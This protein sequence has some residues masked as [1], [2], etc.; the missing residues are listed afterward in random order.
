MML[1]A[2]LL[3][4]II[5]SICVIFVLAAEAI[6]AAQGGFFQPVD[7][8]LRQKEPLPETEQ[9][10]KSLKQQISKLEEALTAQD[11][12]TAVKRWAEGVK[13]R[14]GALQYAMLTSGLKARMHEELSAGGWTTGT[15][16]PWVKDYRIIAKKIGTKTAH[17]E[18]EFTCTDS[19]GSQF[20]S[21]DVLALTKQDG[22][23]YISG[24]NDEKDEFAEGISFAKGI[25][26]PDFAKL[27]AEIKDWVEYSRRIASA[28]EKHYNGFRFVLVTAGEKPTGGYDVEITEAVEKEGRLEARVKMTAPG[29]DD[30]VIAA[31]TY[32]FDLVIVEEKELPLHFV[33]V[34]DPGR[35]FM[36]LAGLDALE[37]PI[38]A[39][40]EWIKVFTPAPGDSVSGKVSL[41]G[42]ASVFEGTV[43]YELLT[44]EGS[45]VAQGF[46]TAAMGDWGFFKEEIAL[47]AGLDGQR[48][49]LRLYS[50][51]GKDGSPLFTVEIPLAVAK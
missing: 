1:K 12:T 30:I 33:D 40:S 26:R 16:S 45:V 13:A 43:S 8:D 29:R 32:P 41:T 31:F 35:H 2:K 51:S 39:E 24:I 17:F 37:M 27:P 48:L 9:E 5:V 49:V 36:R 47:P 10:I 46:T 15:S 44:G 18:V 23:W 38:A 22:C 50:L 21:K 34:D 3:K 14:N 28:Q 6:A 11:A 19:T 25:Y 7:F 20:T 4:S 42:I